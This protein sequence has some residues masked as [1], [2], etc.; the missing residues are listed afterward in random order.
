[1]YAIFLLV[2]LTVYIMF[3]SVA[4]TKHIYFVWRVQPDL[5][6]YVKKS[7]GTFIWL[8]VSFV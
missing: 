2:L 7:W 4:V 6:I 3:T 5:V 8:G 1:M